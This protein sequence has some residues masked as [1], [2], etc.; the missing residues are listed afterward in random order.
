[1]TASPSFGDHD[2]NPL[3]GGKVHDDLR[4]VAQIDRALDHA[5]YHIGPGVRMGAELYTLWPDCEL[6]LA[7]ASM[8]PSAACSSNSPSATRPDPSQRGIHEVRHTQEVRHVGGLGRL[9]DLPGGAGLLDAPVGH[10]RDAI[11]HRERF[12]LVVRDVDERDPYLS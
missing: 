4:G 9:V 1:M 5:R 6:D 12:L 10:H 11:G 2:L 3:A 7:L 8:E